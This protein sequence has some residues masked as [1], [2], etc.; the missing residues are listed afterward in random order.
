MK[1]DR[2]DYISRIERR[3]AEVRAFSEEQRALSKHEARA[4]LKMLIA[5]AIGSATIFTAG[6]VFMTLTD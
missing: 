2:D 1:R 4:D 3:Q 5:I 6:A